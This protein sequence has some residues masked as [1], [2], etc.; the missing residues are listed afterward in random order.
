MTPWRRLTRHRRTIVATLSRATAGAHGGRPAAATTALALSTS[1]RIHDDTTDG[2]ADGAEG[3]NGALVLTLT[4][5][6]GVENLVSG[7]FSAGFSAT[8]RFHFHLP[9]K[10]ANDANSAAGINEESLNLWVPTGRNG[11][12]RN[13]RTSSGRLQLPSRI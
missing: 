4:W 5:V 3:H 12:C 9:A 8:D 2:H 7:D 1:C 10:T 6:P 13:T 11:M